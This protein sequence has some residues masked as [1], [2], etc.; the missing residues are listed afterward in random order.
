LYQARS[1]IDIGGW[2]GF[3]VVQQEGG[4]WALYFD[5]DSDGLKMQI[6]AG[7]PVIEIGLLRQEVRS[8]RKNNSHYWSGSTRGCEQW[9][10]TGSRG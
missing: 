7:R 5:R 6:E 8:I 4:F 9:S 10:A 3:V 1:K 2:E